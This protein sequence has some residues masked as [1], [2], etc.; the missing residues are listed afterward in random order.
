[1]QPFRAVLRATDPMVS[2]VLLLAVSAAVLF[3]RD[4]PWRGEWMWT[5]DWAAGTTI[6]TGPL[7]AGLAAYQS[8]R[9][10]TLT[11]E[12]LLPTSRR[13]LAACFAPPATVLATSIAAYVVGT[14]TL[15]AITVVYHPTD[16]FV[17]VL[18]L[19]GVA[20]VATCAAAGWLLGSRLRGYI[21]AAVAVAACYIVTLLASGN[22]TLA[23]WL[24]GGATGPP[25]G[26]V[27]DVRYTAG[28]V[29]LFAALAEGMA[30]ALL[31]QAASTRRSAHVMGGLSIAVM[32]LGLSLDSVPGSTYDRVDQHPRRDCR[33]AP[34]TVCLLAGNTSQLDSWSDLMNQ[35]AGSL[36]GLGLDFPTRYQQP[37][38]G[39]VHRADVGVVF[40]DP[41]T[42]NIRPPSH[43][44]VAETLATPTTCPAYASEQPPS[45]GLNAREWLAQLIVQRTWPEDRAQR[46]PDVTAWARSTP[47][48][49]QD[50][51]IRIT[52]AGLRACALSAIDVPV[53]R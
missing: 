3:A 44:Y 25:S 39:A 34:V 28:A 33:G 13:R 15:L 17:P 38:P 23:F 45:Q 48:T 20:K 42:I 10:R 21:A 37:A 6:L 22:R 40:F 52:F 46:D 14:L 32:L 50:S 11:A 51:W 16:T 4:L 8:A 5:L 31:V 35:A 2:I 18:W 7:T 19:V 27:V 49:R 9:W 36:Q 26:K 53:A 1:M 41:G 30:A 43:L 24:V 29:L 12:L 47:V